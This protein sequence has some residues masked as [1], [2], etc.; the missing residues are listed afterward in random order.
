MDF[1]QIEALA[2]VLHQA[3][4]LTELDICAGGVRVRLRRQA[5]G[6]KHPVT[7]AERLVAP[8][9]AAT[10]TTSGDTLS[11]GLPVRASVVGRFRALDPPVVEGA[12]VMA[13][14]ALAHIETMG[15]LSDCLAPI[16]GRVVS[17]HRSDDQPVEYGQLLFVIAPEDEP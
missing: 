7:S 3:P 15:L 9:V 8:A 11:V 12:V 13:S 10:A 4:R 5:P 2:G 16:D 1:E 6:R 14:Q 17:V